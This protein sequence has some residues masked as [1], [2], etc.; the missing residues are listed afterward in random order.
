L[1]DFIINIYGLTKRRRVDSTGQMTGNREWPVGA[2]S[3]RQG[4]GSPARYTL[5][6]G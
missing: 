5:P 4:D 3:V 6:Q 2:C 1:Y